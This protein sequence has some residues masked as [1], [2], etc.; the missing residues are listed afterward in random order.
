MDLSSIFKAYDVRGRTDTGD[1]FRERLQADFQLAVGGAFL[2]PALGKLGLQLVV[3][4]SAALVLQR[5]GPAFDGRQDV[6]IGEDEELVMYLS[7]I[8]LLEAAG[9]EH[10]EVSNFARPGRRPAPDRPRRT[11][12]PLQ[13]EVRRLSGLTD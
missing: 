1:D 6:V 13:E 2:D 4:F 7:G 11:P 5:I 12:Q 3:S 8:E 9:F 10:Y